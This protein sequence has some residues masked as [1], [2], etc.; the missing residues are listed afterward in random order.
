LQSDDD[1][2]SHWGLT[3]NALPWLV[4]ALIQI[5]RIRLGGVLQRLRQGIALIAGLFA[6]IWLVMAVILNPMM[7]YAATTPGALVKGPLIVDSLLLAYAVPGGI[8]L[9]S[10]WKILRAG[11]LRLGFILAGFGLLALYIALE[12]RRFWHGD[13]LGAPIVLQ[14]ELYAYTVAMM[15]FGAGL[16]YQAM[17]RRSGRLRRV[18]MAVIGMTIAKVFLLDASGLSG[19]TRVFSFLG[20]GL[21]LAGLAWLNRWA[22]EMGAKDEPPKSLDIEG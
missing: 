1:F 14:G 13:W 9:L 3:L 5:Y 17:A 12:I 10:A 21:S 6:A 18:A 8:L 2:F 22:G 16:F 15:L 11:K 7:F 4:L 20:L 19:L